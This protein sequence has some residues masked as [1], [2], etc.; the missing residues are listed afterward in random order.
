[1]IKKGKGKVLY[2]QEP[3]SGKST[4]TEYRVNYQLLAVIY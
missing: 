4:T 2:G 3:L 1:M